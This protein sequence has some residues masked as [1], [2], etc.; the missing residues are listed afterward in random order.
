[1]G[2]PEGEWVDGSPA[3]EQSIVCDLRCTAHNMIE[4][5]A[6]SGLPRFFQTGRISRSGWSTEAM[7]RGK[8][9]AMPEP[10]SRHHEPLRR[11]VGRAIGGLLTST[12]SIDHLAQHLGAA[13][14]ADSR[15]NG[16]DLIN[17]LRRRQARL[18]R[19][20]RRYRAARPACLERIPAPPRNRRCSKAFALA[21]TVDDPQSS[22]PVRIRLARASS[23]DA[24][25]MQR[26][27]AGYPVR[28]RDAAA[29][30]IS[31]HASTMRPQPRRAPV[32]S[33]RPMASFGG[34]QSIELLTRFEV[35]KPRPIVVVRIIGH[36]CQRS[37]I[38]ANDP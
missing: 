36:P 10:V 4:A 6:V 21:R 11:P 8:A 14:P 2:S 27:I 28:I 18:G 29:G 19:P 37:L 30:Y 5:S 33:G 32:R 9:V 16:I 26:K 12:Q 35:A 20:C 15:K 34:S 31:R 38:R 24:L 22:E 17:G 7:M 3:V 23:P 25:Q 1:M 13:D